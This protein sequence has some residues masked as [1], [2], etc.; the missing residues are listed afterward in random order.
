MTIKTVA[1][2]IQE[3]ESLDSP[4]APVWIAWVAPK[5][6]VQFAITKVAR[7]GDGAVYIGEGRQTGFVPS[8]VLGQ[9]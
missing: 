1:E 2:L 7:S 6:R 9:T 3:L 5:T 8:D 4:D